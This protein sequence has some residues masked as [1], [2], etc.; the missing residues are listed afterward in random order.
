ML[1]N[2]KRQIREK[3]DGAFPGKGKMSPQEAE[4][5]ALKKEIARLK[6]EHDI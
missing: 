4:V 3:E 1:H 5:K 6:E 2:W